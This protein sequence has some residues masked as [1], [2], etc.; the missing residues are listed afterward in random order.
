MNRKHNTWRRIGQ[1]SKDFTRADYNYEES[2]ISY[3]RFRLCKN[4]STQTQDGKW[5]L[6]SPLDKTLG[7]VN[8][9]TIPWQWADAIIDKEMK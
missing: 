2:Y 6:F 7:K 1:Y 9:N 5:I 3:D 8:S 4:F